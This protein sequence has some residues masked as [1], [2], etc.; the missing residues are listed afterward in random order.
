MVHDIALNAAALGRVNFNA[1]KAIAHKC[2][3]RK[4]SGV[5]HSATR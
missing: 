4:V 2:W 3:G 1:L 5:V